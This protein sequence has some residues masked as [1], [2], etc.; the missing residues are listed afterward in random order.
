MS[1]TSEEMWGFTS[2]WSPEIAER[3]FTAVPNA[4]LEGYTYLEMTP[5]EF[6]IYVNIDS[7][8]WTADSNPFPSIKT[9]AKRTGLTERSVT[10]NITSL[11]KRMLLERW[12]RDNSSN[13]Y[14]FGVG[15]ERLMDFIDWDNCG[16]PPRPN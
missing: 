3:G 9:L 5:T 1:L 15:I 8:R 6:L 4:L 10:R 2:K 11:Q 16:I 7:F 14:Y 13:E 12:P